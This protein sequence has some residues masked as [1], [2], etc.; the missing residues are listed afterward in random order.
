MVTL[1]GNCIVSTRLVRVLRAFNIKVG[2]LRYLDHATHLALVLISHVE[3][4]IDFADGVLIY[5][6]MILEMGTL[7][8]L[9]MRKLRFYESLG[10][11]LQIH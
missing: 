11:S 6:P 3:I 10:V 9:L 2:K 8:I 1:L 4:F 5:V 7:V